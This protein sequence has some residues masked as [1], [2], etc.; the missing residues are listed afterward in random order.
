MSSPRFAA[1][2]ERGAAVA[3]EQATGKLVDYLMQLGRGARFTPER[4]AADLD[5]DPQIVADLIAVACSDE[6]GVLVA[7][8]QVLCPTCGERLDGDGLE[9]A[10]EAEG[11]VDCPECNQPIA[12]PA[13]LP[14]EERYRL[15][16][17]ADAAVA[18]HQ[19][20]ERT[21]PRLTAVIL[22]ALLVELTAV[23]EE[24]ER[25][26]Q[27]DET[28]AEGGEI[29]LTGV[30]VGEHVAW[31]VRV[32]CSERSNSAAAAALAN[33]V[34]NFKPDV[35]V[36]GGVAGGI[37]AK[38]KLGD[39]VAADTVFEYDQ[40]KE[41]GQGYEAR[42]VQMPS[43]F[44]L[45]QAAIHVADR[46]RWRERL[47]AVAG[48]ATPSAYVEPIASGGKVIAASDSPTAALIARIA[49]RAVAVETEGAGF[50]AAAH[51]FQNVSAIVVRGI[52]DL[53][54]GK[55]AS[56]SAGLQS[57]AAEHAAAFAFELLHRFHPPG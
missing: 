42:P 35:A 53:L 7:A 31:E 14:S 56:D 55:Q 4:I 16:V 51:R 29:Y 19:E 1:F 40:G 11:E 9:A 49:P 21:K 30:F 34:N 28:V 46:G 2:S 20:A 10:I 24:F 39:V 23:R 43:A 37:P 26:T 18:S 47:P 25:H 5:L 12:S 41:T 15:S 27:V 45:R 44:N 38:V 33:A 22:C 50:L 36:F 54:D 57:R 13:A 52:S 48:E 8:P 32:A 6:V 3:G 17:E